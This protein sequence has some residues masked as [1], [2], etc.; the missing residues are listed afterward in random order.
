MSPSMHSRPDTDSD[1]QLAALDTKLVNGS[2]KGAPPIVSS[3]DLETPTDK[4]SQPDLI[5]AQLEDKKNSYR[6]ASFHSYDDRNFRSLPRSNHL[7]L[8]ANLA[9]TKTAQHSIIDQEA[10]ATGMSCVLQ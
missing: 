3:L 10:A 9:A 2:G 5:A 7:N 8:Y 1:V 4:A 6:R